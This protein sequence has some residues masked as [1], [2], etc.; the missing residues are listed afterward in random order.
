[1]LTQVCVCSLS[2]DE[3]SQVLK[4]YRESSLKLHALLC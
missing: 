3:E 2:L 4:K 1:M